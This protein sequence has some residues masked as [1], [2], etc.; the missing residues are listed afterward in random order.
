MEKAPPAD[1]PRRCPSPHTCRRVA[2]PHSPSTAVPGPR[3]THGRP[4]FPTRSSALKPPP[5]S[6]PWPPLRRAPSRRRLSPSGLI[7][8]PEETRE[9]PV[10]ACREYGRGCGTKAPAAKPSPVRAQLRRQSCRGRRRVPQ[11]SPLFPNPG[12]AAAAQLR[13]R[14]APRVTA[15]APRLRCPRCGAGY[16]RD[17]DRRARC[18]ER[19]NAGRARAHAGMEGTGDVDAKLCDVACPPWRQLPPARHHRHPRTAPPRP[20]LSACSAA[21]SQQHEAVDHGG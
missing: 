18:G 11:C 21:A 1:Q 6:L 9:P 10:R 14:C 16:D 5:P 15:A 12:L 4:P 2:P 8:S 20:H 7:T 13:R 3:R 17:T 19:G